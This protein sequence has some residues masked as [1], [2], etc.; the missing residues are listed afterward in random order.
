ML[1][2]VFLCIKYVYIAT[3]DDEKYKSIIKVVRYL[4]SHHGAEKLMTI[5]IYCI[6]MHITY[7]PPHHFLIIL[8]YCCNNDISLPSIFF[9]F[10]LRSP[11]NRLCEGRMTAIGVVLSRSSS[12]TIVVYM[13]ND[14]NH[15]FFSSFYGPLRDR[16][17]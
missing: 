17:T 3:L 16:N 10:P 14:K 11:N 4:T 15:V 5:H 13:C 9:N 2:L 8:L 6:T 1:L 12:A 7:S